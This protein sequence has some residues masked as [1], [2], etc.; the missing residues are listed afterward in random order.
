MALIQF[1]TGRPLVLIPGIQGRWEYLRPTIDAL[2]RSFRVLTFAL[3]GERASGM[4]FDPALG[5]DNY[6]RQVASTLDRAGAGDAII[7]GISFGGLPAL[8]FAAAHPERTGGLI[9]VSTPGPNWRLR[10]RHR[11]YSRVPWLFGPLFLIETPF[12][13]R[14]ELRSTFPDWRARWRFGAWQLRTLIRAPLS[15]TRMA[16]RAALIPNMRPLDDCA[17]ISAPTLVVT[18]EPGLDRVVPVDA[19]AAYGRSIAQA[20]HVT[21]DKTGHLGTITRPETFASLV[22]EFV[23]HRCARR[24]TGNEK[25]GTREP[26]HTVKD[27]APA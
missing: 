15:P 12:R 20:R 8:R 14:A 1:G 10:P 17:R 16:T 4:N 3:S 9:L 21:L 11:V 24:R 27:H 25:G 18:G 2:A 22:C 6:A 26:R 5:M 19:T 7:C 23:E 13:L